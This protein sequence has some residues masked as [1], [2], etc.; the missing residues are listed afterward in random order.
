MQVTRV[1]VRLTD[2]DIVKAYVDIT[3]DDCLKIHGFKVLR[4]AKGYAV[5]MP[6]RKWRKGGHYTIAYPSTAEAQRMIEQA[7]MAEK[8]TAGPG[9]EKEAPNIPEAKRG[10]EM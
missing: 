9:A 8:V 1:K 2:Q 7:V 3:L 4:H 6:Q 10:R 5:A